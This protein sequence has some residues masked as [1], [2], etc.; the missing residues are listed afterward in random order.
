[1][2]YASKQDVKAMRVHS[3][4]TRGR[5]LAV[6]GGLQ[7]RRIKIVAI[8]T[9]CRNATN[10]ANLHSCRLSAMFSILIVVLLIIIYF[11]CQTTVRKQDLSLKNQYLPW[12][13]LTV[14]ASKLR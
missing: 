4:P 2:P 1:M 8:T 10:S 14:K 13:L 11:N 6:Q 7:M 12:I 5:S 9:A 3:V